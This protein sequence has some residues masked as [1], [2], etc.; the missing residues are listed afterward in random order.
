MKWIS[1]WSGFARAIPFA[2][3]LLG[4]LD[5]LVIIHKDKATGIT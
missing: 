5:K 4:N 2:D 3:S 1:L